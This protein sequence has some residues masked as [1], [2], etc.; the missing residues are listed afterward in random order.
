MGWIDRATWTGAPDPLAPH[1]AGIVAHLNEDHADALRE[2]AAAA[3]AADATS[4]TA[5][6][7]DRGGIE[8][9][10]QLPGGATRRVRASF[11]ALATDPEE[12][13]RQTIAALRALAPRS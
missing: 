5:V 1:A 9:L 11:A 4:A 7:V 3:G 12:V 13:R 6:T 2:L 10:A 8:L